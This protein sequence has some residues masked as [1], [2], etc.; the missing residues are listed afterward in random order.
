MID[1]RKKNV[2][3][4]I[5]KIAAFIRDYVLEGD[6]IV[7]AVSGGMDSDIV[8]RLCCKS[9]GNRRV[10]LFIVVQDEMEEKFLVNA[11]N[12]AKDLHV[13]LAEIHLEEMNMELMSALE[14]G[15]LPPVF[16]TDMLLDPA[17][18]KCSVRSAVISSYQ[19]KGF[20]IAG[21]TNRTEKELGFFLTFGDN[22]ANFKP[23]AHLYK[24]E[25]QPFAQALGTAKAVMEQEPS[26]GFWPGQTDLE[27]LAYWIVNDGPI[28]YPRT[29]SEEEEKQVEIIK[30][31]LSV[32]V[33]DEVLILYGR[34]SDPA[35]ISGY[36]GIPE[37]VVK[38]L[39]HI[40]EK[41]KILKNRKI[42]VEMPTDGE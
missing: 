29:F 30:S 10:R 17:K 38:G 25:L 31:E 4:E 7:V 15:E 5:E 19:D 21:T 41:A 26:A 42:L 23:I 13:H 28:V 8:A 1:Y 27:D 40:V 16:R 6:E 14:N 24:S 18:A 2:A 35:D 32:D 20:L 39:I 33:I 3:E 22:L 11:R 12:L 34:H 9:V 37:Y 36:T